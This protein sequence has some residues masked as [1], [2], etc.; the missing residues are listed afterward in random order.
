[1]GLWGE[2]RQVGMIVFI[3]NVLKRCQWS[4]RRNRESRQGQ[5]VVPESVALHSP[6]CDGPLAG[7]VA[8][9]GG[10]RTFP[11]AGSVL[12][13]AGTDVQLQAFPSF[14]RSRGLGQ[15]GVKRGIRSIFQVPI[16]GAGKG[17]SFPVFHARVTAL[18]GSETRTR[19]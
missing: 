13:P 1:M 5:S 12:A 16:P 17:M 11:G 4:W 7:L 8:P 2:K 10:T 19:V 9:F 3:R 18:G 14:P 15:F 6:F